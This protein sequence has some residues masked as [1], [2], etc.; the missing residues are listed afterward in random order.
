MA[1]FPPKNSKRIERQKKKGFKAFKSIRPNKFPP[2]TRRNCQVCEKKTRFV[3]NKTLGH[4]C[5]EICGSRIISKK[6]LQ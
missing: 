6:V 1:K 3:Y 5:C 2:K 4:S